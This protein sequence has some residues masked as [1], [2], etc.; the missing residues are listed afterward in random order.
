MMN[1]FW[2]AEQKKAQSAPKKNF[3]SQLS[4]SAK[5]SGNKFKKMVAEAQ[6]SL[7][8]NADDDSS[9]NE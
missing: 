1:P 6:K 2:Q 4:S 5:K 9:D 8:S 3:F 7:Y